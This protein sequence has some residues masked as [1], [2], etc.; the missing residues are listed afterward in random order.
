MN[1]VIIVGQ[2]ETGK[3]ALLKRLFE[4]V[5][6]RSDEDDN[7]GLILSNVPLSTRYYSCN[8]DFMVDQYADSNEWADWCQEIL[9]V[10]AL[11]LRE[12]VNGII[13]VFDFSSNSILQDLTRL[14]EVYDQ[15]EQ[16]FLL[17]NKDSIQWEGIKL[18]IG[19]SR[20]PVAQQVLDE[21]YDTS[22]EKGIELVD[23]SIDSQENDYGEAAGIRRVKEILETCSW[24]DVV[25]LR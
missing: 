24:P 22:L 13:F 17:R 16:E 9:G 20:S 3:I 11:D 5:T 1:R 18:A 10:E 6:E 7:S 15:I 25:K 8:L 12:A 21:V 23:L 4:G 2:K 19:L 14:S